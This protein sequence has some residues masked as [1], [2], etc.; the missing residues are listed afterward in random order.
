MLIAKLRSSSINNFE[1]DRTQT[2][3]Q[4]IWSIDYLLSLSSSSIKKRVRIDHGNTGEKCL[5]RFFNHGSWKDEVCAKSEH[6][7][8]I[9]YGKNVAGVPLRAKGE[10]QVAFFVWETF[11]YDVA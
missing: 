3:R 10:R 2:H 5:D 7:V 8:G 4:K 9:I 6:V 11:S 1:S